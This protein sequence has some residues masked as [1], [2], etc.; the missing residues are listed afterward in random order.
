V[1]EIWVT[2]AQGMLGRALCRALERHD[3]AHIATGREVD[4]SDEKAVAAHARRRPWTHILNCAAFTAVDEAERREADA[5]RVN[6]L[7]AQHLARVAAEHDARLLHV[8][9]DYV[10]DGQSPHAYREN[11]A[12]APLNAYGRSKLAG[13]R[14]VLETHPAG[15]RIVRTSWLFGPD[16]RGHFV[17]TM[18]RL[19]HERRELD[20]VGDQHGRPTYAPDLADAIL[21]LAGLT[22]ASPAPAGIYH[23][24][25]R[26]AC[27]WHRFATG[28]LE[29][30]KAHDLPLVTESIREVTTSAFPRP[31]ARPARSVLDTSR[32]EAVLGS[33]PRPW[34][35]TLHD[36]LRAVA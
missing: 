20:V 27:S 34:S 7:G 32:I 35:E 18:L 16:S 3:L 23:F 6:A 5:E 33:V 19:M 12:T 2:G 13:E 26:G 30:G 17:A 1:A 21:R 8:S 36:Y 9:T 4:V 15:A 11:D 31:A 28:I 24:A 22:E 29:A 25:N 10:F 14:A